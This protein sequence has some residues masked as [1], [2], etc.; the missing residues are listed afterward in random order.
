MAL[1]E[2]SAKVEKA[3]KV[4]W[5][6]L[7]ILVPFVFAIMLGLIIMT[8][9]GVNVFDK[10]QQ[11]GSNIPVISSVIPKD[12]ASLEEQ[13]LELKAELENK[14]AL[15]NQLEGDI[16]SKEKT[17]ENLN[18]KIAELTTQLSEKDDQKK[19]REE[20]LQKLS[21]SFKEMEPD[22]AARIMENLDQNVAISVLE[23]LPDKERGLIFAEMNPEQAANLTSAFVNSSE[24]NTPDNKEEE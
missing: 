7:V 5:F 18:S 4:Q 22:E 13:Q 9:A 11:I 14:T 20:V 12:E 24:V 17:I 8:I 16:A 3:G 1:E 23:K 10:A 6:L 19:N 15:V 2:K 21:T